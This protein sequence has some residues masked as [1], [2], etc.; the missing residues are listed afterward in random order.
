LYYKK[1]TPR[2]AGF[3][4][5]IFLRVKES[6]NFGVLGDKIIHFRYCGFYLFFRRMLE[7]QYALSE[8]GQDESGEQEYG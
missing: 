2:G 8:H 1:K 4:C 5:L 6:P 7:E 3:F